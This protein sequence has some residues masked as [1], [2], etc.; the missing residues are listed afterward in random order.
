M[1]SSTFFAAVLAASISP[2][3]VSAR[4]TLGFALGA[5]NSDGS[6]KST[7]DY[8]ADFA[9][10][11]PYSTLVRTYSAAQCNSSQNII[12]AA[13]SAGFQV[14]IGVWPDTDDS[15]QADTAALQASVPGNED[16]VFG[17]TVG[18][19]TLYRGNFTGPQLLDKINSVQAMFPKVLIGTA[20]SWNKYAD[21]T[22]D[23]LIT[24][25]VKLLLANAFSYWQAQDISN[26]TAT[27]FDDMMQ[28]IGHIQELSGSLD[29]VRVMNGE[30]G[31]PT[32]GGSNYGPATAGT[33]NAQ[34]YW[35]SAICG[36]LDWGVDLF[37]FE[38]FDEPSKTDSIG[39][40][41]S[42][43]DEK[44]W[45]ALNADRSTKFPMNC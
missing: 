15:F 29:A 35:Q 40:D 14:L 36:M 21:G 18:S 28:A 8:E 45:G 22:A 19:E 10:L 24:G 12:P 13:K 11:K 2:V 26:A 25:G 38:A 27:Y 23:A 17:I 42:A 5:T 20:D 44:H 41:G 3:A 32:D 31:W 30:T 6:C 1:R 43:A 37:Y 4:G 39:Q 7:S 9:A 16:A 33:S 34:T